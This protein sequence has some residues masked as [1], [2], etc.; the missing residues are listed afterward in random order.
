MKVISGRARLGRRTKELVRRL[1][2]GD[3]AVIDHADLDEVAAEALR[4][5]RVVAVVNTRPFLTGRFPHHGPDRLLEAG[6]P[7]LEEV[8]ER[9]FTGL[10]DGEP[11]EIDELG[12]LA[13]A[14]RLVA[15]G[16]FLDPAELQRRRERA[17]KYLDRAL[18]RFVQNTLDYARREQEALLRPVEL[19]E[20]PV[21]LSGRQVVIVVRGP[22]FRDDLRAILDY[23]D[24]VRPV[25]IGVDGGADGLRELGYEPSLI[26]GDMDSVSD[27][28]L[29]SCPFLVVH[30]Y[31]DGR[32]PGLERIRRL[33]LEQKARVAPLTGTSEDLALILAAQE[34]ASLIVLVGGHSH[35]VDFLEKGRAGM[36]S[37]LLARLRVGPR[38]IDA[39]GVSILYGRGG[40]G[41]GRREMVAIAASALV[42]VLV[43]FGLSPLWS[44]LFRL[45]KLW[46]LWRLG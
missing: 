21:D 34:G 22:G 39:R 27:E 15:R 46:I 10:T 36:A 41:T 17:E 9:V 24:D 35:L 32:A 38:L 45:L 33:G 13:Q 44:N 25:T 6:I 40:K 7:L 18:I 11:I 19:P 5:A 31:P 12:H 20:L 26:V 29:R 2:P 1:A 42:P 43:L 4:R 8:D 16:V 30:A 28:A 14:G 37:T 3:I 23:L